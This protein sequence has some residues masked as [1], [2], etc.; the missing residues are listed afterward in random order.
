MPDD[1]QEVRKPVSVGDAFQ[2]LP[3][4]DDL[5]LR[6]QAINLSL[7]DEF[8]VDWEQVCWPST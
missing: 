4:L 3:L 1:D 6:M 8:L 5:F 2:S 7:I